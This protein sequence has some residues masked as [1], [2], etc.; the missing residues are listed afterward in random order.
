MQPEYAPV[1]GGVNAAT[2]A[3]LKMQTRAGDGQAAHP[4]GAEPLGLHMAELALSQA[5]LAEKSVQVESLRSQL[6]EATA[7]ANS[8]AAELR[9][10]RRQRQLDAEQLKACETAQRDLHER[11]QAQA[12]QLAEAQRLRIAAEADARSVHSGRK[13]NERRQS[14]QSRADK[15]HPLSNRPPTTRAGYTAHTHAH[16]GR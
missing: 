6:A 13:S 7:T 1:V 8:Q 11:Q 2:Q 4:G 10:L 16:T 15:V 9:V 5:T 14:K 12:L 3:D